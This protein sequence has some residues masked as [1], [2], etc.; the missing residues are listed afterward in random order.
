MENRYKYN[1]GVDISP[2]YQTST[3]LRLESYGND[4]HELI[5]NAV[6]YLLDANGGELDTI[7]M[8][9]AEPFL[10]GKCII[11]VKNMLTK[12]EL[13]EVENGSY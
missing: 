6:V 12:Q 8:V 1:L 13:K 11:A 7:K 5:K 9:D 4:R 10:F 2:G 3:N